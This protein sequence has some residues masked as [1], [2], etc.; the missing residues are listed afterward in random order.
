[1]KKLLLIFALL[2]VATNAHATDRWASPSGSGSTCSYASPCSVT[3][4][5]GQLVSGDSLKLKDGTYTDIALTNPLPSGISSSQPTCMI[6]ES[7]SGVQ[8]VPSNAVSGTTILLSSSRSNICFKDFTMDGVNQS[9]TGSKTAIQIG[10]NAAI[11]GLVLDNLHIRRYGYNRTACDSSSAGNGVIINNESDGA[12]L[13]N[14][15]FDENGC[16]NESD[17]DPSGHGIYWRAS[18]GVVEHNSFTNNRN[19]GIQFYSSLND[20]QNNVF[21]YNYVVGNWSG[22][23]FASSG[24]GNGTNYAYNNIIANN[25]NIGINIAWGNYFYNNTVYGNATGINTSGSCTLINNLVVGNSTNKSGTCGTAETTNRTSGTATD[26]M[27]D[28]ANGNF[29]LKESSAAI[30]A[31]TVITGF[32]E[33]RYVGAGVDQGALEAPTR[34]K[35]VVEDAADTT[36]AILFNLPTQST[37]DGTG[38]QTC[39]VA[40]FAVVVD[41]GGATESSCAIN[42]SSI[43][44]ITLGA[45]VTVGQTLT[46]AMTRSAAPSLMDNVAIGD[47]NGTLG[48]NYHNA[49]VLTYSAAAGVNNVDAGGG[50]PALTQSRF[51][52]HYL[53]GTEASPTGHAAEN[54]SV[55]LPR[56]AAFRLR[57]KFKT[58]DDPASTT[59]TLRYSKDAG[60]Y[61]AIP[62]TVGADLISW[63]GT[64]GASD[65][66]TA[67][68]ATTELLTS[69]EATNVACAVIRTSADYPT[70]DFNN[71]ETECEYVIQISNSVSIGTTYDFRVYK[72]DGTALDTYTLTP[73]LTIGSYVAGF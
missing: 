2:L 44:E 26:Y 13:R 16:V 5:Q 59:F 21:R 42:G 66:P 45:A 58:D 47:P 29:S 38:L 7:R 68:T 27:I 3:T 39:T 63:Y 41:G 64:I 9:S 20:V 15:T 8:I 61:T 22:I 60:A 54:T 37:R 1:M 14:S 73:R 69:D 72:S 34:N 57:V 28:P 40:N 31:G 62:D 6:G 70:L 48:T 55:T 17:G 36:Y 51:R 24:G 32:S 43:V 33:G 46:D 11:T 23:Y 4:A 25:D 52:F 49:Y 10:N 35:A 30:D 56:G 19:Y 12:I 53:N 71:G 65:I 18:N 50:L 67:G